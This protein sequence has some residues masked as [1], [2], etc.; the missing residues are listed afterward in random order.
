P[1]VLGT[2]SG[3]ALVRACPRSCQKV[4]RGVPAEPA[5]PFSL[6][7]RWLT[8]DGEPYR[9]FLGQALVSFRRSFPEST[10]F[11]LSS[12]FRRNTNQ[13]TA[14]ANKLQAVM[15]TTAQLHH[16]NTSPEVAHRFRFPPERPLDVGARLQL[17]Y[18]LW[19]MRS[20]LIH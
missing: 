12:S 18:T 5:F 1:D 15:E 19:R 20:D 8:R 16:V 9:M 7:K 17:L 6:G 10:Q 14:C 3:Q 13:Q 11:I 4:G 2:S